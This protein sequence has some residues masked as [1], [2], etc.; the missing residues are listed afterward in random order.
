[1][2][3]SRLRDF[4]K[5]KPQPRSAPHGFGHDKSIPSP[6]SQIFIA[7]A[8]FQQTKRKGDVSNNLDSRGNCSQLAAD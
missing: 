8:L 6:D 3:F 1:M 4:Q 2:E 7:T 5:H